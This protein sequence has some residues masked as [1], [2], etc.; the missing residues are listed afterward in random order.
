MRIAKVVKVYPE[1]H[2]VD[3]VFVDNLSRAPLVQV[4]GGG[5]TNTGHVDMPEP[6]PAAKPGDITAT[7]DRDLYAVVTTVA[8]IPFVL[9]FLTPQVSQVLFKRSNFRVTRHASDVYSTLEDS[10]AYT[11]A[12][13]NGTYLKVGADNTLEDLTAKDFDKK[14]KVARN[15]TVAPK[16]HLVV[17]NTDGVQKALIDIDPAT[18]TL[19]LTLAGDLVQTV[20]GNLTQTITGNATQAITGNLTQTVHGTASLAIDGAFTSSAASW[21]HTGNVTIAGNVTINGNETVTGSIAATSVSASTV[22]GTS[23]VVAGGKSGK[24]HTH[25]GVTTG[26]GTSGAPS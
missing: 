1:A 21:T 9:G 8:G 13:P 12:W 2:A 17:K 4:M 20:T 18:G 6:T 24:T 11:M 10:G 16:I 15:K 19:T 5:S 7:K 23:D 25:G 22:T 3:L 14:W 26:S